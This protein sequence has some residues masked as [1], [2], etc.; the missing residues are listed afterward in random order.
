MGGGALVSIWL[1]ERIQQ[2]VHAATNIMHILVAAE[3][4]CA[5]TNNM[6]ILFAAETLKKKSEH[7][8]HRVAYSVQHK[9]SIYIYEEKTCVE[10]R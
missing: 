10:H 6:H 7:I 4:V 1:C 9:D 8:L 2:S 3:T 5:A